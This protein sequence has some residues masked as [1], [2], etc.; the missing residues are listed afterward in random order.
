MASLV[1]LGTINERLYGASSGVIDLGAG[2]A[3]PRSIVPIADLRTNAGYKVSLLVNNAPST[4]IGTDFASACTGAAFDNQPNNDGVEVISNNTADVQKCT[5]YGTTFNTEVVVA[6]T[7]TLNGTTQVA[8]TKTDW[9]YILGVEL[10]SPAVG[11][12]TI[13]EASGNA[14]IKTITA[15]NTSTGVTDVATARQKCY[16]LPVRAVGSGTTTKVVGVVGTDAAGRTIYDSI[17]LSGTTAVNGNVGFKKVTKLLHGDVEANRTVTFEVG[18]LVFGCGA[19][20]GDSGS[21]DDGDGR[22][23]PTAGRYL[24]WCLTNAD[25]AATGGIDDWLHVKLYG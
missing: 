8:T 16:G 17:T 7:I 2:G 19:Q 18:N 14:T 4:V 1:Y 24:H 23:L 21:D 25:T 3:I 10:S 11:T 20:L 13:R 12:I 15:T 22:Y 6:E 9:G 5:I